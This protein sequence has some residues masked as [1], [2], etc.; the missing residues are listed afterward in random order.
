M[1]RSLTL[2]CDDSRPA[3]L[4]VAAASCPAS[5]PIMAY[6]LTSLLLPLWTWLPMAKAYR[7]TEKCRLI[8][9]EIDRS[10]QLCPSH[11]E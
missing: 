7:S 2:S 3:L 10:M 11:L 1:L 4:V 8:V 6:V 5:L 9:S